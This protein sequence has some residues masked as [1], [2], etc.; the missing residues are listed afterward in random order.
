M[1]QTLQ[2]MR[3]MCGVTL[4]PWGKKLVQK[5]N[6]SD[7]PA[8]NL[9]WDNK[10]LVYV[11]HL[12]RNPLDSHLSIHLMILEVHKRNKPCRIEATGL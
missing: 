3:I 11:R 12:E 9:N 1:M 8:G 4:S 2:G 5:S 6:N 7:K 10:A